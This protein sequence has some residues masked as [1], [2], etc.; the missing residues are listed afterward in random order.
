VSGTELDRLGEQV[1]AA[2]DLFGPDGQV[3]TLLTQLI[4]TFTG[5]RTQLEDTVTDALTRAE[6]AET[7]EREALGREAAAIRERDAANDQAQQ[8]VLDRQA[9]E[10]DRDRKVR[11]AED[12]ATQAEEATRRAEIAQG[13]AEGER[14]QHQGRA[15]RA[16]EAATTA[17]EKLA[18]VTQANTAL[19]TQVE[20][21]TERLRLADERADKERERADK[22]LAADQEKVAAATA[23]TAAAVARFT[24]DLQRI[25]GEHAV[26]LAARDRQIAAAGL[27]LARHV[28]QAKAA[29]AELLRDTMPDPEAALTVSERQLRER[30]ADVVDAWTVPEPDDS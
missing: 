9:A 13:K 3:L 10:R 15:D 24:E 20:N 19:T 27:A 18:Q 5:V 6:T 14:D 16:D 25:V 22:V 17:R 12:R 11:A 8:A 4:G 26:A 7:A 23:A 28:Q 21:L 30:L 1:D 2:Q 29:V